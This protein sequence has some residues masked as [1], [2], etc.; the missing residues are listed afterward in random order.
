V[1]KEQGIMVILIGFSSSGKT[2]LVRQMIRDQESDYYNLFSL[3]R[4]RIEW[5]K[6]DAGGRIIP[7]YDFWTE[8]TPEH[9]AAAFAEC[10]SN[11]QFNDWCH[12]YNRRVMHDAADYGTRLY[13]D[14]MNLTRGGRRRIVRAAHKL[15]IQVTGVFVDTDYDTCLARNA[16]GRKLDLSVMETHRARMEVPTPDEFDQFQHFKNGVLI[17]V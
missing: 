8:P 2:A 17:A 5:A 12:R 13:I 16:E 7:H 3:N 15:G 10:I 4:L 6:S 1:D 14:N 9:Y 11:E